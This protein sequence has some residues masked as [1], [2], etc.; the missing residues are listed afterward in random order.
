MT[1]LKDCWDIY[2]ALIHNVLQFF[3]WSTT[4]INAGTIGITVFFVLV[5]IGYFGSRNQKPVSHPSQSAHPFRAS[6]PFSPLYGERSPYGG[7]NQSTAMHGSHQAHTAALEREESVELSGP[8]EVQKSFPRWPENPF[9]C[10]IYRFCRRNSNQPLLSVRV[11]YAPFNLV[12]PQI[13][14]L[15]RIIPIF[16]PINIYQ[17]VILTSFNRPIITFILDQIVSYLLY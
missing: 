9:K 14:P 1:F 8:R 3:G 7:S 4:A 15:S 17:Y 12:T 10:R 13:H 2:V 5:L 6:V 11:F 16:S